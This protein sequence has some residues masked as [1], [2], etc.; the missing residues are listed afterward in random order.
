LLRNRK[1]TA[2]PSGR[3]RP[4]K[5]KSAMATPGGLLPSVSMASSRLRPSDPNLL[6]TQGLLPKLGSFGNFAFHPHRNS[7]EQSAAPGA[8]E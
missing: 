8:V 7:R 6:K 1:A 3:K 5:M 4:L 2:L